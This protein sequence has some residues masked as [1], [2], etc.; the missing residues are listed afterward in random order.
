MEWLEADVQLAHLL[1]RDPSQQGVDTAVRQV[2]AI[3]MLC[4]CDGTRW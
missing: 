4:R 3:L 1:Q 2:A